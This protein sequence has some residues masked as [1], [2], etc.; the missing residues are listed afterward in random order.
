MT[1][2]LVKPATIVEPFAKS[3]SKNTIPQAPSGTPGAASLDLGFPPLTMT[4]IQ[5]GGVP[6]S[7]LDFNGILNW[8]TQH[9]AWVNAGGQFTFDAT[10][11]AF[12]GGYSKGMIL[13]DNAG[14]QSYKSLVNNNSTDFNTTP[15]SIGT[16]WEAVGQSTG[17]QFCG[18]S[19]G[20]A[21]AQVLTPT[22]PLAAYV[23]GTVLSF[24]AGFTNTG[25]LTVNVS[26]LGTR[27]VF[28]ESPTGPIALTGGEVVT[29][30]L[31]TMRDDGTRFQLT[32]TELG[33]AALANASSNT[34]VVAAVSG[35][36]TNG[37]IALF[38]NATGTLIDGGLPGIAAAPTLLTQ[39]NNGTVVGVGVYNC[40]TTTASGGA[41]GV[42]LPASP[43]HGQSCTFTDAFLTWD[44]NNFTMQRNGHTIQGLAAD[45]ACN[46]R[47]LSFQVVWN[48]ALSDWRLE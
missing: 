48:S 29:G 22:T 23:A 1:V 28:K 26:G 14:N 25:A 4:A 39:A 45:I 40:D 32:A 46:V 27:N 44:T 13:Q 2:P 10:L 37:H 36:T 20:S 31:L 21:N 16:S 12:I 5:S 47:G 30:N 34:G 19:T 17:A 18:T 43:T 7:G 8:I 41:F 15:S 9:T 24:I 33:T 35:A 11:S 3:G 38:N 42:L 6:P